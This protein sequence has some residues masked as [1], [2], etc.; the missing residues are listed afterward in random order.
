[1][2]TGCIPT[3]TLVRS[4]EVF[5]AAR[6]APKFGA[7]SSRLEIDFPAVIDRKD[8][9]VAEIVG[10]MANGLRGNDRLEL[11]LADARFRSATELEVGTRVLRAP[12]MIIAAGSHPQVPAIP[13]LDRYVTSDQIMDVRE[14]PRRLV[15]LGGGAVACEFAQL[16]RRFGSE[17]TML[18]RGPRLLSREDP[19]IGAVLAEVF[20]DEGIRVVF[21]ATVE[22]VE[23]DDTVQRLHTAAEAFDADLILVATGRVPSLDD[24]RLERAGIAYTPKGITVDRF[25]RTTAPNIWA[26]GDC[27]GGLMFTHV[28]VFEGVR[29]A[30]NALGESYEADEA[31]AP[32]AVFCDP[33]VATFGL[34]EAD[35]I[36]RGFSV[37]VGAQP[38]SSVGRARVM[39][40]TKGFIKFVLDAKDDTILGC[41]VIAPHGAEIIHAALVAANAGRSLDPIFSSIFIHPSLT[42]GLQSA[43]EATFMAVPRMTH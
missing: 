27:T 8:R 43:A 22:R 19:E 31:F 39:E 41:H 6:S 23:R 25:M 28:A 42:E 34:T 15:V 24:L 38:M 26:A 1:M 7:R 14:L 29:A 20:A 5:H 11:V 18:V 2:N 36:A 30:S 21:G 17:V 12:K 35:A 4:A 3:K 40:E 32:R 9:I 13:G 10:R 33:E 16:F 37:K